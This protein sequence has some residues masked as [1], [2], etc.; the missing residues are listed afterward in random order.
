MILAAVSGQEEIVTLLLE[1]GADVTMVDSLGL[2]ATDWA[3]R[4]GFSQLAQLM[5]NAPSPAAATSANAA[6]GT[7]QGASD[8]KEEPTPLSKEKRG[9]EAA[10][11]SAAPENSS[12]P[13]PGLLSV[14]RARAAA[15]AEAEKNSQ[16]QQSIATGE[17]FPE[18]GP[19]EAPTPL[20]G[21]VAE[22]NQG[23]SPVA[24]PA[25]ANTQIFP[26]A[27]VTPTTPSQAVEIE[28]PAFAQ[29]AHTN[30]A[31]PMLWVLI[32]VTLCGA[33]FVTY[34]LTNRGAN[35]SS[36]AS[37]VPVIKPEE[38]PKP[39]ATRPLPVVAGA[40]AGAELSLPEPD[41][42]GIAGG[43]IGDG[44]KREPVTVRVQVDRSGTVVTA[45]ALNGPENLR[46]AATTAARKATFSPEKLSS[47]ARLIEGTITYDVGEPES[48]VSPSP[49]GVGNENPA[50]PPAAN[51]LPITG[52][53]LAGTEISLPAADY[54]AS[55]RSQGISGTIIVT[56]RVT[57]AGKV[58]SWLTS[59][60]DVRLRMA[61]LKAAKPARFD[62][63][64]LPGKG[65]VV[66]TITYTFKP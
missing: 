14:L 35:A 19:E 62:P 28:V 32:I 9:I 54:P 60:G 59:K 38:K 2:T 61:A 49:A 6:T 20:T 56:V 58:K 40:L 29:L 66:G 46:V 55:A 13:K 50:S 42:S 1:A 25:K 63:N 27:T 23:P 33:A 39:T 11:T 43:K 51:D 52:D 5:R 41:F 15:A 10:V 7:S 24:Q 12:R 36:S 34:R 44:I 47:K 8:L 30:S 21:S 57:R 17:T 31:R 37:A 3:M 4:R 22:T 53:A 16:A 45:K 65:E 48:S 18:P 64:K 26:A